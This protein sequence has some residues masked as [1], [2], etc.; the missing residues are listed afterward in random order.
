M[1]IITD[2]TSYDEIRYILGVDSLELSDN[3]IG[4]NS[5]NIAM[6]RSLRT[7]TT[8]LGNLVTVLDSLPDDMSDD[9]EYLYSIIKEYATYVVAESCCVGLSM[10]A[11]KSDSDGKASQSRF[12]AESTFKDVLVNVRSRLASIIGTLDELLSGTTTYSTY[13]ITGITPSVDKV[14]NS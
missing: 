8:P 14:T 2:L 7:F 11:L 1:L 13:A 4:S 6:V 5:N 9:E 3:A 12:S 10:Y